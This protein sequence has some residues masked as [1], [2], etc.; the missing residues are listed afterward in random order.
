ME[1][2]SGIV[3]VPLSERVAV[4]PGGVNIGILR[5][6]G[7]R[8]ILVDTGTNE[9]AAKKA[10]RAAREDVGGEVVAIL[11]THGHADHF[12][13]NHAVVKRTNA[14]VYAPAFDEV[15]LRQPLLQP[16]LLFGGAD[17][18]DTMRGSFMLAKPSPVDEIV[19]PGPLGVEGLWVEVIP[20]AGHSPGQVGYL[21]DGVFFCADLALPES[22]LEKYKIPYFFSLTDHLRALALGRTVR[23]TTAVP[24]H[25]PVLEDLTPLIDRNQA[26]I[27]AVQALILR[28]TTEPMTTAAIMS[29]VLAHFNHQAADAPSFYLLQPTI[30]AFLSHLH[31]IGRMRHEIVGNQPSWT[32]VPE[33]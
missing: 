10:L 31:R 24:G 22:V 28:L 32:V 17:P 12:G 27:D 6:D 19:G 9:T 25:G 18:V 1:Q 3:I 26:T 4:V 7:D 15:F 8:L 30:S 16:A 21:V 5:G 14:R 23:Y 20:L 33:R 2:G 11:T 13:G 29:E